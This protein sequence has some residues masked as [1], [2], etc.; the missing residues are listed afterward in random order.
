M[1]N[2]ASFE[3]Y[4]WKNGSLTGKG[5]IK[6]IEDSNTSKQNTLN[7][8]IKIY[9]RKSGK[10]FNIKD[11]HLGKH[12]TGL[13]L[14]IDAAYDVSESAEDNSIEL[15]WKEFR[16]RWEQPRQDGDFLEELD[17]IVPNIKQK[18]SDAFKG[19]IQDYQIENAITY[20]ID[21]EGGEDLW[22]KS[23]T[24]EQFLKNII[25][26]AADG[27]SEFK[28]SEINEADDRE[29]LSHALDTV[30][31]KASTANT[32][33]QDAASLSTVEKELDDKIE[34]AMKEIYK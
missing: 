8:P 22:D 3:Q 29:L 14:E 23:D 12:N 27:R 1:I 19:C 20:V 11:S 28:E 26:V 10:Y 9:D 25:E 13:V 17:A 31:V 30:G 5:L 7:A 16:K 2:E 21:N 18:I 32:C 24:I 33:A 4:D 6:M 34:E 15:K